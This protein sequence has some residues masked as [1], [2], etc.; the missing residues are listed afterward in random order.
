MLRKSL[1]LGSVLAPWRIMLWR[2]V[3][4]REAQVLW[5]CQRWR[6]A[7]GAHEYRKYLRT[8]RCAVHTQARRGRGWFKNNRVP[9]PA[10]PSRGRPAGAAVNLLHLLYCSLVST[11]NSI[12]LPK[13]YSFYSSITL[14]L[15]I[16][17]SNIFFRVMKTINWRQKFLG[18]RTPII[19]P[20]KKPRTLKTNLANSVNGACD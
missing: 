6:I 13:R 16:S 20:L 4:S 17:K 7:A 2:L 8:R 11:H 1:V 10:G 9:V 15:F 3:D 14:T 19:T 12:E 5:G 18:T